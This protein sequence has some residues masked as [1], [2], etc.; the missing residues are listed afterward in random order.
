MRWM[1]WPVRATGSPRHWHKWAV[2]AAVSRDGC[3]AG[4]SRRGLSTSGEPRPRWGPRM[5]GWHR[6]GISVA[7]SCRDSRLR[8]LGTW[9]FTSCLETSQVIV[10]CHVQRLRAPGVRRSKIRPRR[11]RRDWSRG[12]SCGRSA[13]CRACLNRREALGGSPSQRNRASRSLLSH[14]RHAAKPQWPRGML[15]RLSKEPSQS[16]RSCGNDPQA[17]TRPANDARLGNMRELGVHSI[18]YRSEQY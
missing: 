1:G 18:R 15:R 5:L 14:M 13:Q 7:T 9:G 12:E 2:A 10:L 11:P 8:T 16:I 6:L 17:P 4:Y 3:Y